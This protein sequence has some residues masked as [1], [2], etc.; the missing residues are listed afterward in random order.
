M[1]L[2]IMILRILPPDVDTA[3]RTRSSIWDIGYLSFIST[4]PSN[5]FFSHGHEYPLAETS[6]KTQTKALP[7]KLS[8][9]SDS[10]FVGFFLRCLTVICLH[11]CVIAWA[12]HP[13]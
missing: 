9:S 13:P 11:V 1:V 10:G 12:L 5:M 6:E 7:F 2:T 3:A 4:N 8:N